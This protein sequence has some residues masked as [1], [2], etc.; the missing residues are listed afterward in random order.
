MT[1][2]SA[3]SVSDVIAYAISSPK[4]L[5]FDRRLEADL[6][7]FAERA[8]WL[9]YRDKENPRYEENA[10]IL[11]AAIRRFPS[12]RLF[13]H[14]R[15]ALAQELGAYGVHFSG[16]GAGDLERAKGSELYRIVSAH[17]L[18]EALEYA[19]RGADAVTLSPIFSTPGKGEPLG[20]EYLAYAAARSPI[21]VIALGGILEVHQMEEVKDCGAAGYAS[22]RFFAPGGE[23]PQTLG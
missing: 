4:T 14:D 21:P 3:G 5:R 10:R 7:R 15:P 12:L 17:S 20:V 16:R 18:E 8:D 19:R 9:L 11:A 22:I 1:P 6:E 2:W 23:K 13:L